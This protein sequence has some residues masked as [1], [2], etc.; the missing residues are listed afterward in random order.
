MSRKDEAY[1]K[2]WA[3]IFSIY[4]IALIVLSVIGGIVCMA[5]LDGLGFAIGLV[6]IL[7]GVLAAIIPFLMA[8]ALWN[9][10][11]NIA[12]LKKV[13][14]EQRAIIKA[15][16][17]NGIKIERSQ[18]PTFSF[19]SSQATQRATR[20]TGGSYS[21]NGGHWYCSC[22]ALNPANASECQNCFAPKS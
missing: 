5:T 12:E 15:L 1:F 11:E 6:S 14:K 8:N 4:A 21:G 10:G 13:N 2:L 18:A 17:D 16:E 20:S 22:G 7:T 3:K 9:I 19:R